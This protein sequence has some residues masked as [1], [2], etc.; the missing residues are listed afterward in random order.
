MITA[1]ILFSI[2]GGTFV[3]GFAITLLL[4]V[5]V[6]MLSAILITRLFLRSVATKDGTR[7]TNFLFGSGLSS[8]KS[9]AVHH[10]K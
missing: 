3:R 1:V 10:T 4:G 2:F 8:A 7:V 9:K 5:L 6:S